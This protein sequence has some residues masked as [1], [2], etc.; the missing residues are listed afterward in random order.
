VCDEGIEICVREP[1]TGRARGE[2]IR[3]AKRAV[4]LVAGEAS[5]IKRLRIAGGT[6]K[7]AEIAASLYEDAP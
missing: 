1:G 6:T 3:R 7:L 5:P 4:T 2:A